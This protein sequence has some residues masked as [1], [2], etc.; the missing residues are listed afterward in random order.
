MKN[1]TSILLLTIL[2]FC[3]A[4]V[5]SFVVSANSSE[6]TNS[7]SAVEN[8]NVQFSSTA[9]KDDSNVYGTATLSENS[10]SG[11]SYRVTVTV[12]SPSGRAHTTQSD[13]SVAPIMHTTGLSIDIEDGAYSIQATFES[14]NGSYDEYDNFTG[15]GNTVS[16]GSTANTFVVAPQI[17]VDALTPATATLGGNRGLSQTFTATVSVT[18]GV[19]VGTQYAVSFN[20]TA[21]T[22]VT[23]SV[24][25]GRLKTRTVAQGTPGTRRTIDFEVDVNTSSPAG[26][27]TNK[28]RIEFDIPG[29]QTPDLNKSATFTYSPTTVGGTTCRPECFEFNPDCPCYGQ[30]GFGSLRPSCGSSPTFVKASYSSSKKLLP[31]CNCSSSPILIDVAGNGF[32]MTS[33]ANG[34][35]FDFNG[36]GKINGKLA[37]TK[38]NSDDAWL[39]LDRNDNNR[40]DDGTELFGNA[41]PQ[42]APPDG[43]ERQ[44]FRALAEYDKT[45]NGGN[46]DGKITRRDSVFRKL[47]LWQD[48]NHNGVSEAEELSRLPALDV[49]AVFLDYRESRRTDEHGNRFK[50]RAKVRDR[51]G[52][53][54]GRWAWDVF[55][56]TTR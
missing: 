46:N 52:A 21:R 23:Y 36:D 14:Q 15:T 56:E 20:E 5:G 54:V 50:Y 45:A 16:S 18:A 39:V 48:R 29:I 38:T 55:L 1:R 53:D 41:T 40:I 37:W 3:V 27:A 8:N 43:E 49:V 42:P 51:Q 28:A 13:W 7:V 12:T 4:A 31:Q 11:L 10:P 2:L 44:G 35:P 33:A 30:G 34:V 32:S 17:F 25:G 47:R 22:G 24:D 9:S 6:K 19:P 26:S